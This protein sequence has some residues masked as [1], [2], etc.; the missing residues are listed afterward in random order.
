MVQQAITEHPSAWQLRYAEAGGAYVDTQ[1]PDAQN[2][3]SGQ[4]LVK[5]FLPHSFAI[6][7]S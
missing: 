4:G 5:S 2:Q 1:V 7:S 6:M 3:T